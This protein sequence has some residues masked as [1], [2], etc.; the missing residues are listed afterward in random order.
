MMDSTNNKMILLHIIISSLL[1]VTIET[2]GDFKLD[3]VTVLIGDKLDY[4]IGDEEFL[5]SYKVYKIV[6]RGHKKLP[7]WLTFNMNTSMLIGHPEMKDVGK[8]TLKIRAQCIDPEKEDC[9][10]KLSRTFHINVVEPLKSAESRGR[11]NNLLHGKNANWLYT[12]RHNQVAPDRDPMLNQSIDH[13]EVIVGRYFHYQI[14]RYTFFDKEDG[15]T[16]NLTLNISLIYGRPL[17]VNSWLF[18]NATSQTLYGI[19]LKS[20]VV[21]DEAITKFILFATD[22]QNQA[23]KD[24]ISIT[25]KYDKH[26]NHEIGL[27]MNGSYSNFINDRTQLILVARNLAKFYNDNNMKQITFSSVLKGSVVVS[28]GNNTL[29]GT[30]CY[31]KYI[32]DMYDKLYINESLSSSLV[33]LFGDYV[34]IATSLRYSGVCLLPVIPSSTVKPAPIDKSNDMWLEILLPALV[35][36]LIVVIIALL[37]LICCRHRRP[38][39]DIKDS[40]KPAFLEDRQPIIFPEELEMVDPSLKPKTPL[41]LP[42]DYLKET[43]PAVPPHG[44]PSPPYQMPGGNDRIQ[45]EDDAEQLEPLSHDPQQ[46]SNPPPY[47]LPPP[48]FNPHRVA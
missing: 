24:A 32:Q 19:P 6:Q 3:D 22:S 30:V 39:K 14:P 21:G 47:R 2:R 23:V 48:Y 8:Y 33:A 1:L 7:D 43:P 46:I 18:F 40:D 45:Y 12:N 13:L 4:Q 5:S 26:V 44:P 42:S 10:D 17:P 41:V 35:A 15:N 28:W 27:T 36:I 16:R 11:K 31:R 25:Y 38:S 29:F 20:D 37:L 34:L 9:Q